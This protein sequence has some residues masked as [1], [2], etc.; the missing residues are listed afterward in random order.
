MNQSTYIFI[1]NFICL[2]EYSHWS[3]NESKVSIL[4][5]RSAYPASVDG[6]QHARITHITVNT[7]IDVKHHE[8]DV[9]LDEVI[10]S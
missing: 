8:S 2:I 3:I 1:N 10:P 5:L 4:H 9:G 6:T 7:R